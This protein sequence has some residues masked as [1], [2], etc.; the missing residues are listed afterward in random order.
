MCFGN[1]RFRKR[2]APGL[3]KNPNS[4]EWLKPIKTD[5]HGTGPLPPALP[6]PLVTRIGT[7]GV[8]GSPPSL[9]TSAPAIAIESPDN[10][11]IEFN[12][13]GI[14][15]SL[16]TTLVGAPTDEVDGKPE[17]VGGIA[18][19]I[20]EIEDEQGKRSVDS[21]TINV[22]ISAESSMANIF[23]KAIIEATAEETAGPKDEI[24]ATTGNFEAAGLGD[25]A[26][27]AS[28]GGGSE[29]GDGEKPGSANFSGFSGD[30][31]RDDGSEGSAATAE[32]SGQWVECVKEVK[33]TEAEPAVVET[34]EMG[35]AKAL[36]KKV[37]I[38]SLDPGPIVDFSNVGGVEVPD[39][40]L[41]HDM[42]TGSIWSEGVAS[43]DPGILL[44]RSGDYRRY[45]LEPPEDCIKDEEDTPE[46]TYTADGMAITPGLVERYIR[47]RE[48]KT[49]NE[50]QSYYPTPQ[51]TPN[52][53]SGGKKP[54]RS[55]GGRHCENGSGRG[56]HMPATLTPESRW[57]YSGNNSTL[58][59]SPYYSSPS[60]RYRTPRNCQLGSP[61]SFP[62]AKLGGNRVPISNLPRFWS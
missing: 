25:M 56:H 42:Y 59:T 17:K 12:A 22:N 31:T 38:T 34:T 23:E 27:H 21:H 36:R 33:G 5:K 32:I 51:S 26:T 7:A 2:H 14:K 20:P 3:T 19:K 15:D 18:C 52:H 44:A 49:R 11:L 53:D 62:P 39:P 46:L 16:S 29:E 1:A 43:R 61:A 6:A 10:M 28:G 8:M 50:P 13:N 47:L 54:D 57:S 48:W 40:A 4:D 45:G 60:D 9:G 55:G 41:F 35:V 37:V 58:G 24:K 30:F